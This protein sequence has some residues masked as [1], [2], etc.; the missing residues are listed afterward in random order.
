MSF[1]KGKQM[2]SSERTKLLSSRTMTKT[3]KPIKA[4]NYNKNSFFDKTMSHS[5]LLKYTKGYVQLNC[6][7]NDETTILKQSKNSK[8]SYI[9]LNNVVKNNN[10]IINNNR[11]IKGLITPRGKLTNKPKERIFRYPIPM[12]PFNCIKL[13]DISSSCLCDSHC[14]GVSHIHYYP[15]YKNISNY[16]HIHTT[17][18]H[19]DPNPFPNNNNTNFMTKFDLNTNLTGT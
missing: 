18:P 4:S 2:S 14:K 13:K 8:F 17:Q 6:S 11:H 1:R 7:F 3:I 16:T 15:T 19:P 12:E 9:D 10:Y 5:D